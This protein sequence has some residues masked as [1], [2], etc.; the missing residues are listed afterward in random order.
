MG[1]HD[2]Y[3]TRFMKTWFGINLLKY[4]CYECMNVCI[5]LFSLL[6]E[7]E[8]NG[9]GGA[10]SKQKGSQNLL[11]DPSA[12]LAFGMARA[13]PPLPRSDSTSAIV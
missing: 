9:K 7:T 6:E 13:L 8:S 5:F 4:M 10:L 3:L 2:Y 1:F 11:S 12:V